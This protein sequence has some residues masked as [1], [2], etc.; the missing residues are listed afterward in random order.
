MSKAQTLGLFR[1]R[2]FSALS[3]SASLVVIHGSRFSG[4][5]TL[6]RT[7]LATDPVPDSVPVFVAAPA[8]GI[9]EREYW[10]HVLSAVSTHIT[11]SARVA[12]AWEVGESSPIEALRDCLATL[13]GPVTLI[14]DG[15]HAVTAAEHRV[16][17]LLALSLALRIIVTTRV[18]GSWYELVEERPRRTVLT[19]TDLAFTTSETSAYFQLS[20]VPQDLRSA[21]AITRRTGGLPALIE[22]VRVAKSAVDT[23]TDGRTGRQDDLI[24]AAVD[25]LIAR[26][27]SDDPVLAPVRLLVTLS[28]AADPATAAS[29][30]ALPG[31]ID[32]AAFLD[33]IEAAGLVELKPS[34][35]GQVWLYPE[36]VRESLLRLAGEHHPGELQNFRAALVRHWLDRGEPHRALTHAFES[37]DWRQVLDI[38]G[39]HWTSLY[40]GG[41][42]DTL[43]DALIER[44]PEEI[45]RDHPT[46][47]AIRRL[48]RQ[49]A[50]P[51]DVPVVAPES[52]AASDETSS[53]AEVMMRVMALRIE[54][55]FMEAAELCDSLAAA[56]VPVFDELEDHRRHAYAF[57]YLHIGITYQLVN[58]SDDAVV[59]FRRAHYA[60]AGM[61]V[62]RDA[63]GKLALAYAMRG[64][65]IDAQKWI[66]EE[67]RHPRLPEDSERLVRTA[68]MVATALI[69]LDRIEPD[70]ALEVLT[71]LGPPA[72][73]EEYWGLV[74]YAHGQHAL[75]TGM[76]ADGLRQINHRL[77]RYPT[78]HGDGAVVGPLLDVVRAD[79]HLALGQVEQARQ[80]V[81]QSTHPLTAAARARI[82]LLTAN[83]AA[84]EAIVDE[85]RTDTR[86]TARDSMELA[87]VG[88]AAARANGN[89]SGA[90]RHLNRAIILS[91][92]TGL[93]RPFTTIAPSMLNDIATLGI[94]LPVDVHLITTQFVVFETVVP[95]VRLTKQERVVLSALMAGGT[96]ATI[97]QKQF[98]SV[99]T[100]KSHMRSLYRKLGVHSR[101][102]AV[103]FA[104]RFDIV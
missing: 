19:P 45:A 48:H 28:A 15:V 82:C 21:R 66:D 69:A 1:N 32:G 12:G 64:G 39:E 30:S 10:S 42:L 79:L 49:F 27:V 11:V 60:G 84:A 83:P 89:Q 104:R 24:D 61:F 8:S 36:A 50:A 29:M 40:S 99:N 75:L 23:G 16:R 88:A 56:P 3:D 80:L 55:H 91:R 94:D 86:C 76:P 87:V 33:A 90:Q 95:Y 97:A 47:V 72:D 26:T 68:G 6:V 7:W 2:L 59:M 18:M 63:A 46:I 70:S 77:S 20:S 35:G 98:V 17:E 65:C 37:E 71:D 58:R 14:L 31:P 100:I 81:A 96:T 92:Q 4:K 52:K 85:Y 34:P 22:A 103:A 57:L 78:L 74:L 73:N 43:D 9:T 53:P 93:L 13:D 102:E 44:I 25:Q 54:G 5:S 41:F 101:E 62:E 51:R 67:H 38:I